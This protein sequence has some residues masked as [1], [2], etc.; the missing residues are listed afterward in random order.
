M[1]ALPS[2]GSCAAP[3]IM[4]GIYLDALGS[5]DEARSAVARALRE[6]PSL[7]VEGIALQVGAHPDPAQGA[8]RVA[9]LRA[10]W[11]AR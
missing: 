10:L 11:P 1:S 7:N 3:R 2:V 8:A 4:L 5:S 9:R 6:E